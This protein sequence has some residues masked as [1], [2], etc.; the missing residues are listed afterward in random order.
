MTNPPS[1]TPVDPFLTFRFV[2]SWGPPGEAMT[3][4]AYA[5]KISGLTRTTEAVSWREG[6]APQG[7]RKIPGQTTYGELTLERGLTI[8]PSFADWA[9]KVW[10]YP[11]SSTLDTE[12]P[13]DIRKDLKIDLLNEAGQVVTTYRVFNCWPSA[14]TALPELDASTSGVAIQSMTL[15]HEGWTRDDAVS[16][17]AMPR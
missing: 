13:D 8:D 17:T 2:I 7:V 9:S 16:T 4:A 12:L 14:F 3:P 10:F 6:G 11:N 5:R 1:T 15:Q